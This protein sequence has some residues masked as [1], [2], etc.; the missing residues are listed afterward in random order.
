MHAPLNITE[1]NE[2]SAH[3]THLDPLQLHLQRLHL[4]LAEVHALIQIL[5]PLLQ[6]VEHGLVLC[7]LHAR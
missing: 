1:R 4:A 6:V 7:N 2:C 3:C 5:E